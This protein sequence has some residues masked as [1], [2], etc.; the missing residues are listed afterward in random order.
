MSGTLVE[1]ESALRASGVELAHDE[2]CGLPGM[3][4]VLD[5]L[6]VALGPGWVWT[7]CV[8]VHVND[9]PVFG[10]W[11]VDDFDGEPWPDEGEWRIVFFYPHDVDV[12]S[13]P[14]QVEGC[15]PLTGP[16]GTWVVVP[17]LVVHR[18]TPNLS[19]VV[20]FMLKFVV[21]KPVVL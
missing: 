20:R 9:Q 6:R 8:H 5:G 21:W 10:D 4:G 3:G 15:A 17:N 1:L 13:G 14:V 18:A 16:A 11:H 2:V 7:D 19:G 12:F